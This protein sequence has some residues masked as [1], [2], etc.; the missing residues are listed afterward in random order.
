MSIKDIIN[1]KPD[2]EL[3]DIQPSEIKN[4]SL[5]KLVEK[6]ILELNEKNIEITDQI[7]LYLIWNILCHSLGKGMTEDDDKELRDLLNKYVAKDKLLVKK[8]FYDIKNMK[9]FD[10]EFKLHTLENH[11]NRLEFLENVRSFVKKYPG[12]KL[13]IDNLNFILKQYY[14]TD[15]TE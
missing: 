12:F 6:H 3:S 9:D 14:G 1:F 13:S 2:F 4:F 15:F 10:E 8:Y 11:K 7:F 5:S